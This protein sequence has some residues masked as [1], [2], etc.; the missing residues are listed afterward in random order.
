MLVLNSSESVLKRLPH[1][2]QKRNVSQCMAFSFQ[3][4]DSTHLIK[5]TMQKTSVQIRS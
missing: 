5:V 1:L 2:N 4:S 3:D